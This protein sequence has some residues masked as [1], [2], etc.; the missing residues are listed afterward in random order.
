MAAS[1]ATTQNGV[2][3]VLVTGAA[4]FV[5]A[6]LIRRLVRDGHQVTGVLQPGGEP[7]RV[8][9]LDH[10]ARFVEV[11]LLQDEAVRQLVDDCRPSW[12]FHLAAYGAYSWQT[13]VRRM[14]ATNVS[15]TVGLVDAC[16]DVGCAAFIH[17]GSSS[18]YGLKEQP[19]S[20]EA[21]IEPNSPYA[22]SKAAATMYCRQ[23]ARADAFPAVTLRLYSVFGPYEDPRRLVP[24][25][26]VNALRDQL[27]PLVD[28]D[29]AR[30]FVWVD[31]ATAAFVLAAERAGDHVG[32]IYNVGSGVQTTVGDLVTRA[33]RVL[34]VRA[35]PAW[36][37]MPRRSWDTTCWVADPSRIAAELGWKPQTTIDDGLAQ[38]S[39]WLNGSREVWGVYGVGG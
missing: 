37:S 1:Q 2:P 3:S 26:V 39:A 38:T 5:G 23:A 32:A 18:E 33:R 13:D 30:D 6:N 24:A 27:P 8:A 7:W 15:G 28:P 11:D 22:V 25:L 19:P 21:A 31:D 14:M 17:A 34:K 9:G 4:G 16:R 36:G 20:E 10:A 35:E 29:V 12:V